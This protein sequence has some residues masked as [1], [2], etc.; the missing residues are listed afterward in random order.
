MYEVLMLAFCVLTSD[1]RRMNEKFR[2]SIAGTSHGDGILTRIEDCPADI[3]VDEAFVQ[4]ELTRRRPGQAFTTER[5]EADEF[6]F[7]SG[8]SPNGYT[9]GETVEIFVPNTGQHSHTYDK[10]A[11]VLRPGHGITMQILKASA[12]GTEIETSGGGRASARLTVGNVA[13]GAIA[14]LV[15]DQAIEGRDV[16]VLAC[17]QKLGLNTRVLIETD[18]PLTEEMIYKSPVRCPDPL[19]GVQMEDG[20]QYLAG[21]GDSIGGTVY[22]RASGFPG[23]IGERPGVSL[24]SRLMGA[25][26]NINAVKGIMIG[27]EDSHLLLGSTV[28]DEISGYDGTDLHTFSNRAGGILGGMS[29]GG[30][31]IEAHVYFKPTSS[32]RREVLTVDLDNG[33]QAITLGSE[34]RHDPCVAIR[35][36]EV[37]K[38][39]VRTALLQAWLAEQD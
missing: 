25:L 22:C 29:T 24:D 39:V 21:Q 8:V 38:G 37:V 5:Q 2:V 20:I 11:H 15:M 36:V 17:M 18:D 9:T 6:T 32:I 33:A 12:H 34:D 30:S 23:A 14:Q 4:Q 1:N 28:V 26:G 7:R 27:A 16:E 10:L 31:P 35:G 13:A 19:V 3:W